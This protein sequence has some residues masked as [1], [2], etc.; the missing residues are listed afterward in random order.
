MEAEWVGVM[1]GAY[2]R[3]EAQS[4]ASVTA[5]A[6]E[7]VLRDVQ[8]NP[9]PC[10][11][12]NFSLTVLEQRT[13]EY[14]VSNPGGI[15]VWVEGDGIRG[16]FVLP[17]LTRRANLLQSRHG[18][19]QRHLHAVLEARHHHLLALHGA[20]RLQQLFAPLRAR[21]ERRHGALRL[22]THLVVRDEE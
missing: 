12:I 13:F 6:R 8:K 5:W 17:R 15:L 11:Q 22:P 7:G 16:I 19:V 20:L 10:R 9:P 2:F 1:P 3:G 21:H 18:V 4:L 14:G